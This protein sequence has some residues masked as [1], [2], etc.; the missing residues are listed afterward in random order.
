MKTFQSK[1][2]RAGYVSLLV[3][4]TTGTLLVLLM[5]AAYKRASDAQSVQAKAQLRIDYAEKEETI[6]RSILTIT[7]NRAIRAMQDGSAATGVRDS[8]SWQRIL[9]DALDLANARNSVSDSMRTQINV[10][11]LQVGNTGD[12]ALDNPATIFSSIVANEGYVSAGLNR[13]LGSGYPTSL[14]CNDT[15]TSGNDAL[16]PIISDKKYDPLAP[17][18]VGPQ[19][20]N[21]SKFSKI[22]YPKINFGY[23]K[24]GE[25]FVAKRNWWAFS[26][27]VAANDRDLTKVAS[28]KRDFVLS[29][30]EIPSQLAISA[31]SFMSLGKYESGAEWEN[32]TIGG[33]MFVG[34]AKVDGTNTAY[35]ALASRRAMILKKGTKIGGVDFTDKDTFGDEGD[36]F[37][38]GAREKYQVNPANI[39]PVSLASESSRATFIPISRGREMDGAQPVY[40]FFDRF[41]NANEANVLS[42]TTWN[43]YSSGAMQAAMRVTVTK[44]N[45]ALSQMP[46]MLEFE[47]FVPNSTNRAVPMKV[48]QDSTILQRL[49]PGFTQITFANN[50]TYDFGNQAMDIA[51]GGDG[52]DP[53]KGYV[54]VRGISG[55]VKFGNNNGLWEDPNYGFR[56]RGYA[57]PRAPFELKTVSTSSD[58]AA[59]KKI[60]IAVYPERFPGFLAAIG[61]D[62]TARNHSLVVNVDYKNSGGHPLALVPSRPEI[63]CRDIDYGLVLQD[64]ADLT[65]F[66]KGFSLV[67][68]LRLYFGD[69][70]NVVPKTAGG[71]SMPPCSL[72][73]PEKRYG[74]EVTPFGIS[75]SGQI[76]SLAQ[77]TKVNNA[78]AEIKAVNPL[79]SKTMDGAT[80]AA[81]RIQV[82][83]SKL[84]DPADLPP[85]TMMNWLVLIEERRSE[86]YAP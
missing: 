50:V 64:C 21:H 78:D 72:F 9:G 12:S 84:N 20:D 57:R 29:I 59:D 49:P 34:K 35:E 8:L 37:K 53:T 51:Y 4:L 67:T 10:A 47:Y 6:L 75:L 23:A 83:L 73:A 41:A 33:G 43:N 40:P 14:S 27:D 46:T 31:A 62:T 70:F 17:L 81:N 2:H 85:I 45:S 39:L 80:I 58:P 24:P 56:K 25:L 54:F 30:Y 19:V 68:N 15:I 26:L 66:P 5:I 36:A 79:D 42:S 69:D 11:V 32:V 82:N 44:V 48:P 65:G 52:A 60:C 61:G 55:K 13:S 63:P 3:V 71:T 16:Y 86:Y 38:Q 28:R 74:V 18:N 77:G 22:E 1:R 76:G 7:P